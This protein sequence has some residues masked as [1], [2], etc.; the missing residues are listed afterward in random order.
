[1]CT[2]MTVLHLSY[3]MFFFSQLA[4]MVQYEKETYSVVEEAGLV[5]LALLLEGEAVIP[6][7]VSVNTLNLTNSSVGDAATGELG[8]F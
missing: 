2:F 7:T 6:V 8:T 4:T 3:I 1:M 5:T